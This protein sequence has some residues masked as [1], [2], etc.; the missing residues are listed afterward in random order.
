MTERWKH[1]WRFSVLSLHF[2]FPFPAYGVRG[3]DDYATMRE[4]L[5]AFTRD[6][7]KERNASEIH[8]YGVEI[9]LKMSKALLAFSRV[10][11][12]RRGCR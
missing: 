2:V 1:S 5:M 9:V 6:E 11:M 12:A 4:E 8:K 3:G 7:G 10:L